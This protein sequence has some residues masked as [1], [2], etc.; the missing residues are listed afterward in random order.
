MGMEDPLPRWLTHMTG[1]LMLS[2]DGRHQFLPT[3]AFLWAPQRGWLPP[4]KGDPKENKEKAV[5]SIM[6]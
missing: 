1:K 5:I 3:Q 2:F 4:E 6:T